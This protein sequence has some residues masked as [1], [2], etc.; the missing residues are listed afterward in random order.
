MCNDAAEFKKVKRTREQ[1]N[2]LDKFEKTKRR[3]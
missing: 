1:T 3:R 2:R